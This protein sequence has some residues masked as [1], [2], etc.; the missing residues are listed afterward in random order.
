MSINSEYFTEK[1]LHCRGTGECDMDDNFMLKL[2]KL[3]K[4][5]REYASLNKEHIAKYSKKWRDDNK[6]KLKEDQNIQIVNVRGY[7]YKLIC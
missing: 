1:E 5:K 6:Q 3:R 7:G 2:E 4:N